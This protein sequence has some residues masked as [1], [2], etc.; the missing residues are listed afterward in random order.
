MAAQFMRKGD[1]EL[2][3]RQHTSLSAGFSSNTSAFDDL[4]KSLDDY[5]PEEQWQAE[6]KTISN[7]SEGIFD[8][9]KAYNLIKDI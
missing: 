2:F 6:E 5:N 9:K 1:K 4:L 7:R 8:P 3:P